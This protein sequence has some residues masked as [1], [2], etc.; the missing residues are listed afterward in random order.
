V[1]VSSPGPNIGGRVPRCPQR[2]MSL[3]PKYNKDQLSLTNHMTRCIMANMLQT[4]KVAA[5]EPPLGWPCVSFAK[6]FGIRKLESLHSL[7]YR[8]ALFAWSYI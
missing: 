2:S 7:A 3:P 5:Q 8:V 4:N 1:I 6:V